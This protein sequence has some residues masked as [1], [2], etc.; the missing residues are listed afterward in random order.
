[1]TDFAGFIV[2]INV[3]GKLIVIPREPM[4]GFQPIDM[5]AIVVVTWLRHAR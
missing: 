3:F 1:L 5:T 2:V 4:P